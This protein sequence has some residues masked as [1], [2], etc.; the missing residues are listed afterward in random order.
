MSLDGKVCLVTGGAAGIGEAIATRLAA[1]GATVC[2]ADIDGTAAAAVADRIGGHS[3]EVDVAQSEQVA[4]FVDQAAERCGHI[5]AIVN[6]AGIAVGGTAADTPETD[7]QRVL[8]TNLTGVWH[9]M[10][11]ALPHLRRT[12][13]CIVNMSSVQALVGLPGWAAYAA[14]KGGIIA[15]TQQAAVEYG[16][17]HVRVNCLAP[18]TIMTP[19]NERIFENATD[20][21]ALIANWNQSHALGRFGQPQEVAAAAAFLISDD[22]SFVTGLCLRVDGGLTILGPT[23]RA[24]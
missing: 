20:P 19:M 7:W 4:R 21:Q 8:D 9:G 11:Y 15:L 13:G 22:A 24:D 2:V 23:G 10:K 5:D 16:P 14:S 18:G 3:W 1:D 12:Q 17:E 6:N